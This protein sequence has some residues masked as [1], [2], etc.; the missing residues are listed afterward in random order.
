MHRITKSYLD[1]FTEADLDELCPK[2][3][4]EGIIAQTNRANY[5]LALSWFEDCKQRGI[6]AA[7]TQSGKNNKNGKLI[8][9]DVWCEG[10]GLGTREGFKGKII[11]ECHGFSGLL[12]EKA[13]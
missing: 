12:M 6:P 10:R 5:N 2:K 13:A 11:M 3:D 4:G 1:E 9:Y 7:I 8:G